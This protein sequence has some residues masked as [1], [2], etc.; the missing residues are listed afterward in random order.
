MNFL[1]LINNYF[2]KQEFYMIE[3]YNNHCIEHN[4]Q[5][6]YTPFTSSAPAK[7]QRKDH[8]IQTKP[9]SFFD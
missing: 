3:F 5:F 2:G 8:W 7:V 9:F 1:E 4:P 6:I